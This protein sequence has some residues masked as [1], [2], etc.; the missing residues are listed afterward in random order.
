M[1]RRASLAL[2]AAAALVACAAGR[3]SAA[4]ELPGLDHP[5]AGRIWDVAAARFLDETSLLEWAGAHAL[6]LLGE[7]HDNPEHHRLEA[8][9]IAGLAAAGRRPTLVLEML[10]ADVAAALE[11]ALAQPDVTA[12]AVRRAVAWE[13][14]GWPEW[15][16]Y[17]PVFEAALAAR[18]RLAPG[19]LGRASLEQLRR[20]G[21][22]GLDPALR[23]R[24]GLDAP[25]PP[26]QRDA[27]GAD[28]RAS[29]CGYVPEAALPRMVDAQ[30]AR[31]AHLADAMLAGAGPDGAL[32]VAGAGHVQRGWAVPWWLA[33]GGAGGSLATLAFLE[34]T[35]DRV[36]PARDL[37]ERFG[38]ARPYDVV[39]YT[40]RGDDV[41][42]CAKF[43]ED[44]ERLR[45]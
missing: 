39:W 29:H 12:E 19:D 30:L 16:L 33:R 18:L 11:E 3:G 2:A 42:P 36:E 21:L 14:S 9:V 34:V 5:L 7:K 26:E 6:V 23:A 25:Q 45:P 44:L 8:R 24:L 41:D 35:P 37:A 40:P 1:R 17:A 32:L 43:R 20:D 15:S 13:R 27:L 22:A 4:D 28:I 31:D 10:P 38:A